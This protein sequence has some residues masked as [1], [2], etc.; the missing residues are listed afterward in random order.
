MQLTMSGGAHDINAI[1]FTSEQGMSVYR[2]TLCFLAGLATYDVLPYHSVRFEHAFGLESST[3]A[4]AYY[5]CLSRVQQGLQSMQS[6][7]ESSSAVLH[8]DSRGKKRLS[9]GSIEAFKE[10]QRRQ[11]F[12]EKS[13]EDCIATPAQIQLIKRRMIELVESDLAIR[14]MSMSNHDAIHAL[15][16]SRQFYAIKLLE[17]RNAPVVTVNRLVSTFVLSL[18][19]IWPNIWSFIFSACRCLDFVSV[20]NRVLAHRTG[21]L[22]AF[23]L[24]SYEGG[25][26][27]ICDGQFYLFLEL[28]TDVTP[29]YCRF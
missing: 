9:V 6:D 28:P 24:Q 5:C 21:L 19:G 22:K 23:D 26:V 2:A 20:H 8:E 18:R 12:E 10:E 7:Q 17:S 1:P 15:R 27:R 29:K 3:L 16:R 11:E 25:M 14:V 13:C 4:S